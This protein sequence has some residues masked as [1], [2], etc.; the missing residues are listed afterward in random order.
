MKILKA[1]KK[2]ISWLHMD[3]IPVLPIIGENIP[4][5]L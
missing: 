1:K 2:K 5:V 3:I 4:A